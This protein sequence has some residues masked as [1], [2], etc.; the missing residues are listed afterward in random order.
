ML[1]T[2]FNS[3]FLPLQ[4]K[5]G[6]T[7]STL[8]PEWTTCPTLHFEDA[9]RIKL[10]NRWK[11]STIVTACKILR[12]CLNMHTYC[13]KKRVFFRIFSSTLWEERRC[14]ALIQRGRMSKNTKEENCFFHTFFSP[15]PLLFKTSMCV[16]VYSKTF[17]ELQEL[18]KM[19][20]VKQSV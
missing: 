13:N 6:W 7:F 2:D 1:W 16:I 15:A 14:A 9:C 19:E 8:K 3:T 5:E 10:N 12:F 17:E 4:G 18:E 11:T 20:I